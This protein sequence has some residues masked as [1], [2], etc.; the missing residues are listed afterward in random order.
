VTPQEFIHKWRPVAIFEAWSGESWTIKSAAMGVS[1]VC[2]DRGVSLSVSPHSEEP[3][4]GVSRDAGEDR[5]STLQ[6]APPSL[7]SPFEIVAQPFETAAVQPPQGEGVARLDGKVVATIH[8]DLS[9]DASN[10]P[11][12]YRLAENG[13]VAFLGDDKG[14]VFWPEGVATD[15]A[16]AR[17]LALNLERTTQ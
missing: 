3:R 5:Q 13:G 17:L 6:S 11:W 14:G 15:D 9:V 7:P 10:L 16:L 8:A 4:S 1:T 12:S 2:F